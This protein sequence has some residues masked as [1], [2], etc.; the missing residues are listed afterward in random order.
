M[1]SDLSYRRQAAVSRDIA[2]T[3]SAASSGNTTFKFQF[4]VGRM[5]SRLL[6][7]TFYYNRQANMPLLS[8]NG[9]PTT[10]HDFDISLKFSLTQ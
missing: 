3:T 4:S 2:T 6:T 8:S 10:T 1:H 7:I 5:L 9:F